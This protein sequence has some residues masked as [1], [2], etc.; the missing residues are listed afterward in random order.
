VSV[1]TLDVH[2]G[3]MPGR[4]F[5][6]KTKMPKTPLSLAVQSNHF[7]GWGLAV[8][9]RQVEAFVVLAEELHFG[10]AARRLHL[11]T[12]TLSELVRRLETELGAP[13]FMRTTR[14]V[15]LT[16]AGCE[17]LVHARAIMEEVAAASAAVQ[18]VAF[19]EAGTVRLGITPPAGP[20]LAPYLIERMA[21]EA[22]QVTVDL[23]RMWLP[24]LSEA[25]EAGEIDICL[26]C[27][28]PPP[29]AGF[30]TEVVA[31]EE[32]LVGLRATHRLASCEMVPLAAL[33]GQVLG[34]P[35]ASLFPAWAVCVT[36]VLEE[37]GISP[38]TVEL[39]GT[40]L[41]GDRWTAQQ[42]VDWTLLIG[43]LSYGRPASAM[44]VRRVHPRLDVPFSLQWNFERAGKTAVG[45][46]VRMALAAPPPPGWLPRGH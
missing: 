39:I 23:R 30:A 29:R 34:V 12:P 21:V 24:A 35:P 14:R 11:S 18:R 42:E 3:I 26:T 7:E 22:P 27:G 31:T 17:L 8:E 5:V 20:T 1:R 38:A 36:R 13:L 45:R 2:S 40:E 28:F 15:A 32:L 43:S 4:R 6:K 33:S 41:G 16:G 44:V 25:L 10:R 19:G 46:F 37:A 9:L